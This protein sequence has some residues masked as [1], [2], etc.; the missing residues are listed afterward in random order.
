[1]I[2]IRGFNQVAVWS[3]HTRQYDDCPLE[4]GPLHLQINNKKTCWF[5]GS[6][7]I[8]I[9]KQVQTKWPLKVLRVFKKNCPP[10][11]TIQ[12]QTSCWTSSQSPANCA[13]TC[14]TARRGLG[15]PGQ[16]AASQRGYLLGRS[17]QPHY[18]NVGP[19]NVISWFITPSNYG[20][21]YYKP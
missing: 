7:H 15:A 10:H 16:L 20:Y 8:H 14:C 2:S 6:Q 21:N 13:D 18:H 12:H 11:P 5:T 4:L 1:M 9:K 19:P 3:D 17:L